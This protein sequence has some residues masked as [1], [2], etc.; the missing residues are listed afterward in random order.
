MTLM[1]SI[2]SMLKQYSGGGNPNPAKAEEHFDQFAQNAPHNMIAEG[3][4]AIFH[5]DQTPAFG[6]LVGHLF[7]QSNGEQKAGLLNQLIG[8]L[9]PGALASIAGSGALPGILRSSR[10][11]VTPDDAQAVSPEVVER[12]ATHAENTDP[13]IVERASSFYAQHP[14]LIK[15]LGSAALAIALAKVA[16]R[17][18]AA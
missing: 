11:Q 8:A 1:D 2:S 7:S 13:S 5:S 4:S 14:T 10:R 12:L 15:T 18:R 6:N 9:G 16:Q 3:L 17:Q